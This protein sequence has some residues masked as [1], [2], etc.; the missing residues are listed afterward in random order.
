MPNVWWVFGDISRFIS[1]RSNVRAQ[2]HHRR[3]LAIE[4]STVKLVIRSGWWTIAAI[5][6]V[7]HKNVNRES[8]E[9]SLE[10]AETESASLY[11]VNCT[12]SLESDRQINPSEPMNI[13]EHGWRWTNIDEYQT[14][15]TWPA[16]IKLSHNFNFQIIAQRVALFQIRNS[17]MWPVKLTVSTDCVIISP[18]ESLHSSRR[19]A[20]ICDRPHR[21]SNDSVLRSSSPVEWWA[22][23]ISDSESPRCHDGA[24]GPPAFE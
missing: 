20:T 2:L 15:D 4:R 13:D 22:V 19:R 5:E 6:S 12:S 21:W 8:P 23:R 1:R 17:N 14:R 24:V 10:F 3:S 11:Q 18:V 16:N 9:L 7:D